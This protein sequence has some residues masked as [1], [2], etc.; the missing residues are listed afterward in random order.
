MGNKKIF[1][2]GSFNLALSEAEAFYKT[3]CIAEEE[4][5]RLDWN[6]DFLFPFVVNL[7]LACELYMKS[8]MIFTSK[9]GTFLKEHDLKKLFDE[10]NADIQGVLQNNFEENGK[11]L[12]EFLERHKN[13]FIDFRY[14]FEKKD[15]SLCVFSTD[16]GNF[17]N[18]LRSYC[19]S[20]GKD[21]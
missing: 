14:A 6:S 3:A 5:I 12:S 15:K 10:L 1:L 19:S 8:I 13:H 16:L 18:C 2:K 11:S 9:E 20:L 21:D 17:A 7:S 4:H